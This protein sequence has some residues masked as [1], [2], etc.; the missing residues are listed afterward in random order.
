MVGDGEA[1]GIEKTLTVVWIGL[2]KTSK[3]NA[4]L[5][6]VTAYPRTQAFISIDGWGE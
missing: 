5:L 2:A 4:A 6:D 1:N 3:E